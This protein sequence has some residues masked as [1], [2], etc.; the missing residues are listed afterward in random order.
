MIDWLRSYVDEWVDSEAKLSELILVML[1]LTFGLLGAIFTA[2]YEVSEITL[3]YYL[4][5][6][7]AYQG[8]VRWREY[9]LIADTPTSKIRSMP[10]GT[11]EVNGR[12]SKGT[13]DS[14]LESPLSEEECL[15]YNYEVEE[16]QSTGK[17]SYWETI[18]S[19]ESGVRF[20]L[21]DG[22]D[23]VI[24]DPEGAEVELPSDRFIKIDDAEDLTPEVKQ[25]FQQEGLG[26]GKGFLFTKTRRVKEWYIP[27]GEELYIFGYAS[28][29][30]DDYG[31]YPIIKEDKRAEMFMISDKSESELIKDKKSGFMLYLYGGTVATL[32]IY[33]FMLGLIF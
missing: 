20:F 13:E 25:F 26:D 6:F 33:A 9:R 3:A 16:L 12:A 24:V 7:F 31:S 22:T 11:V 15:Y 27:P 19:G 21:E 30:H 10:M 2:D 4:C 29:E 14:V 23:K 5:G 8:F 18:S 1:L 17:N 28:K 32:F